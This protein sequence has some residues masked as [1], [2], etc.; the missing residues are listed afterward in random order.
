M[1]YKWYC[2]FFIVSLSIL[3]FCS[4]LVSCQALVFEQNSSRTAVQTINPCSTEVHRYPYA[5]IGWNDS[6]NLDILRT[7]GII[8]NLFHCAGIGFGAG[9]IS[10]D[11]TFGLK[12]QIM[13]GK[14]TVSPPLGPIVNLNPGDTIQFHLLLNNQN[15]DK[16]DWIT[17]NV[18]WVVIETTAE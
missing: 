13:E 6:T 10:L 18:F 8:S 2:K 15:N 3:L 4:S 14:L 7:V 16:P 17:A 9:A 5:K 12:L 11:I 1:K